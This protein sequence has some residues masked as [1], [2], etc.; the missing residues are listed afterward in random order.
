VSS[1]I[2]D[3]APFPRY[4]LEF[5][6]T[7]LIGIPFAREELLRYFTTSQI[8]AALLLSVLAVA[9]WS[10]RFYLASGQRNDPSPFAP[11]PSDSLAL[12]GV[13]SIRAHLDA[14]VD[15]NSASARDLQRLEG[16]GPSL[17]GRIIEERRRGGPY[18]DIGQ[19]TERVRGIGAATASAIEHNIVFGSPDA[20]TKRQNK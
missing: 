15:V 6:L 19:F 13:D 9:G 12:S 1:S 14:P 17:A 3:I 10:V 16:I 5:N 18:Q 7:R 20:S 8:R 2:S 11:W 4:G